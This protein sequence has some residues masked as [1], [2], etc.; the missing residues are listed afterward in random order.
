[1]P[2]K[3]TSRN[4]VDASDGGTWQGSI[5]SDY[6]MRLNGPREPE[7]GVSGDGT[8]VAGGA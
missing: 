8:S 4:D 7:G 5:G 2:G 1:V 6:H 3:D